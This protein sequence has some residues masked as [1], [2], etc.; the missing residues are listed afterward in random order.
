[1]LKRISPVSVNQKRGSNIFS[2]VMHTCHS[3]LLCLKSFEPLQKE[4]ELVFNLIK[5]YQ[6]R[7]SVIRIRFNCDTLRLE[8]PHCL[9]LRWLY[10]GNLC[11]YEAFPSACKLASEPLRVLKQI[12][13]FV[14]NWLVWEVKFSEAAK[15]MW[16]QKRVKS[17]RNA[18]F[19][20][21]RDCTPIS[22]LDHRF[23]RVSALGLLREFDR[24]DWLNGCGEGAGETWFELASSLWREVDEGY[25]LSRRGLEYCDSC[26]KL[27][28]WNDPLLNCL[29][30]E[31]DRG[32]VFFKWPFWLGGDLWNEVVTIAVEKM[33]GMFDIFLGR[34]SLPRPSTWVRRRS[35]SASVLF[36]HTISS[37]WSV[38]FF[39][40]SAIRA[41]NEFRSPERL[42]LFEWKLSS[43]NN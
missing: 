19:E 38:I 21:S 23:M 42:E 35:T 10:R 32:K 22:W 11:L 3:P 15:W 18:Y 7:A 14:N 9:R 25:W 2:L 36:R 8:V 28:F 40:S 30:K 31:F 20:Y 12:F 34:Q 39:S 5:L 1:M 41:S 17:N 26:E 24:Y 37:P 29:K 6:M 43:V 13:P 4:R 16:K 27:P 33:L